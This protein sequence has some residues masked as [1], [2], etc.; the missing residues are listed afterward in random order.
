MLS[1][2]LKKITFK[3][4]SICQNFGVEGCTKCDT[5]TVAPPELPVFHGLERR[6]ASLRVAWRR[7]PLSRSL[8]T[9]TKVEDP[10]LAE[11]VLPPSHCKERRGGT[12]LGPPGPSWTHPTMP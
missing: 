3:I 9:E 11:E 2:F 6:M 12:P 8:I 10:G 1:F 4:L 7:R 5:G